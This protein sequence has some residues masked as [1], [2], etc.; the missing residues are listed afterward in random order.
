MKKTTF[1][2][3]NI[4]S[5]LDVITNSS[6]E[7]FI[8]SDDTDIKA[9]EEMLQYML[10]KYN[11]MAER[12][13]FGKWEDFKLYQMEDVMRVRRLTQI[14]VDED[15]NSSW[16]YGYETDENVGKIVIESQCDNS[17]PWEIVDWIESAFSAKRWHLG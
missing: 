10:D 12:G 9:V 2:L 15:K 4:H 8:I 5:V 16:K 11:E 17:I 6:S 1:V 13:V 3:N 14:E 7:L